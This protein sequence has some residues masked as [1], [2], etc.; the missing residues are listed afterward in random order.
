MN[1]YQ[2]PETWQWVKLGEIAEILGGGT[3]SRENPAYFGGG[4]PWAT[5][6]DI[7]ALNDLWI[8]ET[9]ETI[10]H[11]GLQKS[12]ARLLPVGT[13]LMTS[14]ATIGFTALTGQEMTTNQG[15]ASFICDERVLFNEYLAYYLPYIRD[16]LIQIAGGTTFKEVSKSV[17]A[18]IDIPLPSLPE[19]R[20]IAEILRQ[21]YTL[22]RLRERGFDIFQKLATSIYSEVFD[23]NEAIHF[24]E[25]AEIA[26][27]ASGVTKGRNL[28]GREVIEVPYMRVAN[29]QAGYL[30][31]SEVKTIEALPEELERYRLQFEDVL[32]TEG[33]D[34]DKLGRGALWESQVADCIHQ[35]HIFRVRLDKNRLLPRFF[36]IYLQ[37]SQPRAYFL[38]SAKRTT[39]IAS[40]NMSQLRKMPV[41]LPPM[42]LQQQFVALLTQ[43]EGVTKDNQRS[44]KKLS[45]LLTG[46]LYDAFRGN[47]TNGWRRS[48][49]TELADFDVQRDIVLG[50]RGEEPTHSDYSPGRVTQVERERIERRLVDT[51]RSVVEAL[52]VLQPDISISN[53]LGTFQADW[54]THL[55]DIFG[56]AEQIKIPDFSYLVSDSLRDVVLGLD[57]S[58][59]SALSSLSGGMADALG[60]MVQSP[61]TGV[62]SEFTSL[63]EGWNF[64]DHPRDHVLE[65]LMVDQFR[66]FLACPKAPSTELTEMTQF[67]KS[68]GEAVQLDTKPPRA[69]TVQEVQEAVGLSMDTIRRGLDLLASLGLLAAVSVPA[70]SADGVTFVTAYQ[71]IGQSEDVRLADLALL[72]EAGQA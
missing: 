32:L 51:S 50:L 30:D 17:L 23:E 28:S 49:S 57:V 4:I 63:F 43:A 66:I 54:G 34:Y 20:R 2:L 31:L 29:V 56:A 59:I 9:K 24:V 58:A 47:L 62:L 26:E 69:V 67:D 72:E 21:A 42:Q 16:W 41:P 18:S 11:E 36:A 27:I 40:I 65:E 39:N 5:P 12:S 33:G 61:L 37:T 38:R 14:R 68:E 44:V 53:F 55:A 60:S 3:P 8:Y 45:G 70:E 25:L 19:Q 64:A 48:Q 7:T 13:V 22:R 46:L 35:N 15:F 52:A 1:P 71:S 10:T 6:T